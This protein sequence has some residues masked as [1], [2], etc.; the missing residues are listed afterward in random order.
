MVDRSMWWAAIPRIHA[1]Y[2]VMLPSELPRSMTGFLIF[3]DVNE[4]SPMP[5]SSKVY[6]PCTAMP[7][8]KELA[9]EEN[10]DTGIHLSLE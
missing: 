3:T 5:V 6:L 4:A 2:I 10:I 7:K 1:G 8:Q 9:P